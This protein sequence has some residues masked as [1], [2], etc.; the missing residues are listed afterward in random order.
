MAAK[1]SIKISVG[2]IGVFFLLIWSQQLFSW[3]KVWPLNG[4]YTPAVDTT[5]TVKGWWSESFQH[6]HSDYLNDNFGFRNYFV[7]LHNQLRFSVFEK[8]SANSVVFGK[9]GFLYEQNY[10]NACLGKDYIGRDTISAR[11]KK[12][13]NI[14]DSL[15]SFGV[16]T[17]VILA[18][19]KGSYFPEYLPDDL[20]K[21]AS[22]T[23]YADYRD[24]L[25]KQLV[26]F[27]DFNYWFRSMKDTTRYPLYGKTGI[28][29]S[30]YGVTLVTDSLSR[31]L[32]TYLDRPMSRLK[33]GPVALSNKIEFET[34]RDLENGLNLIFNMNRFPM[35]YPKVSFDD[36]KDKPH[37]IMVA[38]SYYWQI[39]GT[40]F[41]ND[42]FE[43]PLYWYYFNEQYS[44]NGSPDKSIQDV[45]VM[46]ELKKTNVLLIMSTDANLSRFDFGFTNQVYAYFHKSA[47]NKR[48]DEIDDS[49]RHSPEWLEKIKAKAK[50]EN[51]DLDKAIHSNAIW[52]YENVPQK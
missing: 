31:Y 52:V 26:P 27:I 19:G 17:L 28:H 43:N 22:H 34:D 41:A 6:Q 7:R 15:A 37:S 2:I 40:G 46:E 5:I 4:D 51:K 14:S 38:D 10:V 48:I 20:I 23:N 11:V 1:K 24:E 21:K 18:P 44:G 33:L 32:E 12:L 45:N 49:I 3:K 42:L 47:R 30:Y 25:K 16:K 39:Y 13:K 50:M 29:W 36:V 8:M 9:E 35:A